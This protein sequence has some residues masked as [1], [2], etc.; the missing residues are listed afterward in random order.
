MPDAIAEEEKSRRLG[1]LQA[2]QREI[3]SAIHEGFIGRSIEVHVE[4]KSRREHQWAGH[5][6]CHRVVNL[7]SA[8]PDLLGKYVT[9]RVTAAGPNSLIGE[10]CR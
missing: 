1:L 10:H 6:S 2:R 9:V 7:T 3:Q 8:E 4:G 5:T